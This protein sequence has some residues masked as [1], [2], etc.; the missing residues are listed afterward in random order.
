MNELWKLFAAFFRIGLFTFGG[1]YSM[2]PMLEHEVVKRHNWVTQE[3][4]LDYFALG[5]CM[6]GIIAA[7]VSIFIG[8][9]RRGTVGAILSTLGVVLPSLIIITLIAAVLENFS[10]IPAV[11]HAFAGIRVAVAAL[12]ASAVVKLFK[13]NVLQKKRES[14]EGGNALL[15]RNILPLFL[16]AAA[17]VLVGF[18]DV[19][20]VYV[21]IGAA[22]AGLLLMKRGEA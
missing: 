6:P 15:R 2:L 19:S 1:G 9:K 14:D 13:S 12:I 3:E 17:F 4:M 21:V 10:H 11:Q 5:Q 8:Y 20:P 7:N 18:A 16:C 22:V